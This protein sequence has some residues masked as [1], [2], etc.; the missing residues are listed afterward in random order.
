MTFNVN[1]D[2]AKMWPMVI[3]EEVKLKL[4]VV[5]QKP[6]HW[7]QLN[8]D[9]LEWLFFEGILL[10]FNNKIGFYLNF[11]KKKKEIMCTGKLFQ[12]GGISYWLKWP[13]VGKAYGMFM[14]TFLRKSRSI[15]G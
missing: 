7:V 1:W 2:G 12:H 9:N 15:N 8:Y 3:L 14:W 13:H 11:S 10:I 4:D 6:H 5:E